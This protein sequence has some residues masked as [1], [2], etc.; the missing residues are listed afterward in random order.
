MV[1]E[2]EIVDLRNGDKMLSTKAKQQIEV[3]EEAIK[4]ILK[5]ELPGD[6]YQEIV[7]YMQLVRGLS[8]IAFLFYPYKKKELN[9]DTSKG[10]KE[11]D[12]K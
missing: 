10:Y 9:R 11:N 8:R 1:A 2:T 6:L 3:H 5:M 7:S 12:V 4:K